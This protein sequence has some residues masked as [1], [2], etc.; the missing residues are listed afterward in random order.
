MDRVV[1]QLLAE[2]DGAQSVPEGSSGRGGASNDVFVI[3][4]TN[5]CV[6]EAIWDLLP[7]EGMLCGVV[8]AHACM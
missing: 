8:C 6:L 1:A 5:R 7:A 2:M 4:A 3:G